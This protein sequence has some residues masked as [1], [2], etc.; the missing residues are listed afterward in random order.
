LPCWC[1]NLLEQLQNISIQ[2][3]SQIK[4][5]KVI[6]NG[7]TLEIPNDWQDRSMISF[8]AP[9][10]EGEFTPNVFIVRQPIPAVFDFAAFAAAQGEAIKA[11]NAEGFEEI[12]ARSGNLNGTETFEMSYRF[13]NE[14]WL[15]RQTQTLIK[16]EQAVYAITASALD[17]DFSQWETQ[18][19][20][21]VKSFQTFDAASL[22]I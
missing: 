3:K 19:Q 22:K 1:G 16:A 20:N 15:V 5:M 14:D 2:R 12:G 13:R 17:K 6:N 10:K 7:F 18:F 11:A 4:D 21:I 9:Y 8:A